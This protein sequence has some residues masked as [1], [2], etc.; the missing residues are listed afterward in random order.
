M[1]KSSEKE[2]LLYENGLLLEAI[3]SIKK[4]QEKVASQHFLGKPMYESS[5]VWNIS[6]DVLNDIGYSNAKDTF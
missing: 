1:L 4:H 6:N 3:L 5:V 2:K